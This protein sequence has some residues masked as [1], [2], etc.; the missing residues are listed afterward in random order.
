MNNLYRLKN[1][2]IYLAPYNNLS[3]NLFNYMKKYNIKILGYIDKFKIGTN[4]NTFENISV[5][6]DYIIINSP[7]Y[8]YDIY[9]TFP[10]EKIFIIKN[11][12]LISILLNFRT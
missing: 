9:K 5:E 6:Y 4:I 1:K 7:K 2:Q 11:N 3:Q 8:W 10:I 12:S